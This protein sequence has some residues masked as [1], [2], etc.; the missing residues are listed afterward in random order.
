MCI[1]TT[2]KKSW[3]WLIV[4]TEGGNSNFLFD[5]ASP[6]VYCQVCSSGAVY[7][8]KSIK[9]AKKF[10]GWCTQHLQSH[11]NWDV[12]SQ[13]K[14]LPCFVDLKY[15][16]SFVT[17]NRIKLYKSKSIDLWWNEPAQSS[18]TCLGEYEKWLSEY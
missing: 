8:H 3:R 18:L 12:K 6:V 4:D 9:L 13:Q 2:L 10:R 1:L 11:R 15:L 5:P 16:C 14:T 7:N 17:Y